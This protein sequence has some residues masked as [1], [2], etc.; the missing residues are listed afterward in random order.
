MGENKIKDI[1][2]HCQ[3]FELFKSVNN[4]LKGDFFDDEY[5]SLL[6]LLYEKFKENSCFRVNGNRGTIVHNLSYYKE[7][8][9]D[10]ITAEDFLEMYK[11]YKVNTDDME[12]ENLNKYINLEKEEIEYLL[13][14]IRN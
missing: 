3:T 12:G 14:L 13:I 4:K 9:Y 10:I 6:E 1:I 8:G 11:D 2:I 5:Y 7:K